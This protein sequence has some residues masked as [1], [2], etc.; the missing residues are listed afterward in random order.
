[1]SINS[2]DDLDGSQL[3]TYD[4]LVALGADHKLALSLAV[5]PHLADLYIDLNYQNYKGE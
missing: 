2:I 4:H 1:M 3:C 5:V